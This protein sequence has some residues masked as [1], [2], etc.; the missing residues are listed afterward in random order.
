MSPK[1][2]TLST[3][4]SRLATRRGNPAT[5]SAMTS[6]TEVRPPE[7]WPSSLGWKATLRRWTVG[8]LE[9]L[10]EGARPTSRLTMVKDEFIAQLTDINDLQA[11]LVCERIARARS[12]R[13]LWHLRSP[14][15]SLVARHRSQHEADHRLKRLNRHF[16]VRTSRSQG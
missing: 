3:W 15:Y 1:S 8:S 2:A 16:S 5:T 9:R 13:E 12:L 10:P 7:L 14:L 4:M 6:R 11:G